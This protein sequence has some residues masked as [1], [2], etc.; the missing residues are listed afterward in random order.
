MILTAVVCATRALIAGWRT[1]GRR[2]RRGGGA[3]AGQP[4]QL[5]PRPARCPRAG[6]LPPVS[7]CGRARS[8]LTATVNCDASGRG[9]ISVQEIRT[10]RRRPL[11]GRRPPI[12][13]S[14][15]SAAAAKQRTPSALILDHSDR[16]VFANNAPDG[17]QFLKPEK[18]LK[19]RSELLEGD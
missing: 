7:G 8:V 17:R 1:N 4:R 10:P 19:A 3:G 9:F 12:Q 18:F 13:T 2:R 15:S 6:P 14:Y 5:V 16:Q 11:A